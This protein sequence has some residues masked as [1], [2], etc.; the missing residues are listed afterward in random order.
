MQTARVFNSI[1]RSRFNR[2]PFGEKRFFRS[3]LLPNSESTFKGCFTLLIQKQSHMQV[4]RSYFSNK[5]VSAKLRDAEGSSVHDTSVTTVT[6]NSINESLDEDT[7]VDVDVD[8]EGVDV[9]TST[10]KM[11]RRLRRKS[12]KKG[13]NSLEF[14]LAVRKQDFETAIR[15][16]D[17]ICEKVPM[18]DRNMNLYMSAISVCYKSEHLERAQKILQEMESLFVKPNMSCHESFNLPVIRCLCDRGDTAEAFKL[19]EK[20]MEQDRPLR[21]RTFNPILETFAKK[22]DPYAALDTLTFMRE[23]LQILPRSEQVAFLIEAM[24]NNSSSQCD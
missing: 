1:S 5:L 17:E 6:N 24:S 22:G 16:F 3:Y 21:L 12:G 4:Y 20:L 10:R 11:G 13:L 8:V 23:K 14:N 18:S 2:L 9:E 19:I 15:I 7:D